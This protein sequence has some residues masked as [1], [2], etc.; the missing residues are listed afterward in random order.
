M[1]ILHRLATL[2]QIYTAAME[3]PRIVVRWE[4]AGIEGLVQPSQ[5]DL[6]R[7]TQVIVVK[8]VPSPNALPAEGA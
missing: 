8:F 7:A 1:R 4:G 6:D 2:E 3:P 5:D